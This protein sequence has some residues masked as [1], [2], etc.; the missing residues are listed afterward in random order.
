[1]HPDCRTAGQG[2]MRH[3]ECPRC[4]GR[5]VTDPSSAETVCASCGMVTGCSYD[6]PAISDSGGSGHEIAFLHA[7]SSVGCAPVNIPRL[8][9]VDS[10]TRRRDGRA[11]MQH[12]LA[13]MT[14]R[15]CLP[16]FVVWDATA[17]VD[18]AKL[19]GIVKRYGMKYVAASCMYLASRTSGRVIMPAEIARRENL[20]MKRINTTTRAIIAECCIPP[21][22]A[23]DVV[24]SIMLRACNT[25]GLKSRYVL[26]HARSNLGI[27][28]D[29]NELSG[30]R[31]SV[32]A[33]LLI[34]LASRGGGNISSSNGGGSSSSRRTTL[35]DISRATGATD[36]GIR[37]MGAELK[38]RHIECRCEEGLP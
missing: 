37:S 27:L 5:L 31:P 19:H 16:P 3:H 38:R 34:W 9:K 30:K 11:A 28:E 2:H 6:V 10:I 35:R 24:E 12:V 18:S 26:A 29:S 17:L 8:R 32:L 36:G 21:V 20:R 25:L 14:D 23:R 22:S 4:R 7:D 15:A 1:M 13:G 33:G